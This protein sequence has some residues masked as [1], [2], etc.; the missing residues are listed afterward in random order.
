MGNSG[1]SQLKYLR[2]QTE[3]MIECRMTNAESVGEI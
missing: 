2:A 3:T 1:I